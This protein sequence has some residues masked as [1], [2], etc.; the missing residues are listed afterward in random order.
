[1]LINNPKY[2]LDESEEEALN[3]YL[4]KT[5]YRK[6]SDTSINDGENDDLPPPTLYPKFDL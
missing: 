2:F 3:D 5:Y 4:L 6:I 1:M